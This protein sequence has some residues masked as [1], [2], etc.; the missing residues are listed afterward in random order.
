MER[1]SLSSGKLHF[2]GLVHFLRFIGDN[3]NFGLKYYVH[4]EYAP[5][6][7]ILRHARIS[8]DN[9]FMVFSDYSGQ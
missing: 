8:T 9:Q 5:L 2:D 4:I 3:K 7:E 6:S 1:F